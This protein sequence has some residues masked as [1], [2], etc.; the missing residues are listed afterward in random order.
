MRTKALLCA[1][2]LVASAAISMAQS[3]VYSLN[4]V[5]Y[6]NVA[7]PVGFTFM[8]NPL[9]A[10]VTNG[11][12]EV[13]PNTGNWDFCEIHEW[14][15]IGY[16]VSVF[17]SATA[18]TTTGF[19]DRN[20][21]PVQ[22]PVLTS[23]KGYLFNNTVGSAQTIT[24]VG[25]VRVGTNTLTYAP[26]THVY[27]V[28]S[29]LP[30]AGGISSVLNL[31]NTGGAL[32]FCEVQTARNNAAGAI[33]GFQVSVF[34]SSTADTT[35]GFI[36]RNYNPVPEPTMGIGQGYFFNNASAATVTWQQVLLNQ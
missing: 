8:S 35:T 13:I 29:P 32:D 9:D 17:D 24:Y 26:S 23:G 10:G 27:A 16:K 22:P 31:K 7:A 18:D 30:L 33:I 14:T 1:A 21:N 12:N 6:A 36:D 2:A 19:I 5:G 11:A 3:N 25:N 20:Y 15:G 28:G 34:D 4:I